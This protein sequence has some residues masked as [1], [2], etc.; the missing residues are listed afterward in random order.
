MADNVPESVCPR[1]DYW[2]DFLDIFRG[3]G[4]TKDM[5]YL[6]GLHDLL[7]YLGKGGEIWPLFIGKIALIHLA[8]LNLLRERGV[9]NDPPLR[10]RY[11]SDPTAL[12]RLERARSGIT[13]VDL[14]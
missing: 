9:I 8:D 13:V 4:F 2:Q 14:L 6:R 10:P 12:Q 7:D 1:R 5:I 11:A 3:G